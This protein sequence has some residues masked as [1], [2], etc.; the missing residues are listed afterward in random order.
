M[1][2]TT[3]ALLLSLAGPAAP[4]AKPD[5]GVPKAL[6]DL[7]PADTAG[8]LVVDAAR[9]G[10]SE[11]GQKIL[12]LFAAEQ[13]PGESIEFAELGREAQWIV[14]GQFLIEEGVG[15]FCLIARLKEG[16]KYGPALIAKARGDKQPMEQIGTRVV[17]SL[18][19][20]EFAVALID[21][22]TLMVVVAA[23]ETPNQVKQTRAAAFADRDKPGPDRE[24]RKLIEEGVKD[25]RPVQ[26]Y[27]HHPT[28]LARAAYLPLAGFGVKRKAVGDLGDK[29]VSYR[30]GIR[31]G[32]AGEVEVRVTAKDADGA[33]A[34]MKVYE[35]MDD[36]LPPFVKEF[37]AGAKVVREG[38]EV[39]LTARLTKATVELVG[40]KRN[41]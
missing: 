1:T 8:V 37:R 5:K 2:P 19:R 39:V 25:D 13:R 36:R 40:Q 34:L 12:N 28:K 22:R 29:L 18:H 3:V 35:E 38:E 14:L 10:K 11:I 21:D 20:P 33:K 17:Y 41:K 9:A 26:M 16:A 30:G 4:G 23:G 7:L 27:G 32:D 6:I 31:M 15:D 24:L